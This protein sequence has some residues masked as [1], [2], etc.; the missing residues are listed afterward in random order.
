MKILRQQTF[1]LY[2][3]IAGLAI[4]EAL[5][6][7]LPSIFPSNFFSEPHV[8]SDDW[9]VE[10]VRLVVFLLM[11]TRFYFGAVVFFAQAHGNDEDTL[12][13][14][15]S[16]TYK[17]DFFFGFLHFLI[18]FAWSLTMTSAFKLWGVI[19]AYLAVLAVILFYGVI[20]VF[21]RI[22][23]MHRQVSA[24]DKR[25]IVWAWRNVLTAVW[26]VLIFVVTVWLKKSGTSIA[27]GLTLLMVLMV[28]IK[29]L[30]ELLT[31]REPKL[32]PYIIP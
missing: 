25:T 18:F 7:A 20:W 21:A 17:V 12:T 13:K 10:L 19:S 16:P 22:G 23:Y 32:W 24:A 27:E 14:P 6:T 8:H 15:E 29:D 26:C 1:W 31:G 30:H 2:G 4:R 5:R 3:V 28:T 11:I 9:L